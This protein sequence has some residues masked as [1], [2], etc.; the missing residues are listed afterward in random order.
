MVGQWPL[1]KLKFKETYSPIEFAEHLQEATMT[2]ILKF[3][4]NFELVK[5]LSFYS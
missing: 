2:G 4:Y 5:C 1:S 3:V